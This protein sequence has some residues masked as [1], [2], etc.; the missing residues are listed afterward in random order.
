MKN[1][2]TTICS[3]I[4]FAIVMTTTWI[5][6]VARAEEP[7][8]KVFVF[9]GTSNLAGLGAN[10]TELPDDLKG[11]QKDVL[12]WQDGA[13]TP[14]VPGKAPAKPGKMFGP[15]VTFGQA[16]TKHLGEPI[17]IITGGLGQFAV[18]DHPEIYA[19]LV[20]KVKAA[21]KSRPIVIAGLLIQAGERDGV[22]EALANAFPKNLTNFI[23]RVRKD[24]G[25]PAMPIVVNLAIPNTTMAP[26][27]DVVR[28]AELS[29]KLPGFA[30]AD[31]DDVQRGGDKI[32]YTTKGEIEFGKYFATA[33]IDLLKADKMQ[34]TGT[35][36]PNASA[37]KHQPKTAL[38]NQEV[39]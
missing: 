25:T 36:A 10:V 27:V 7:P 2:P 30:V 5:G 18:I 14:L 11:Q 31:C 28:K 34:P 8:L 4:L 17:G 33:M 9:A 23:D 20:N 12:V 15:E 19:G 16:M 38:K 22:T 1:N 21:Q 29:A 6:S 39:Q 32:H 35:T 26:F 3:L 24:F 37:N 13:W